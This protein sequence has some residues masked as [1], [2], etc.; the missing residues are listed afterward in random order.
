MKH[1]LTIGIL[2]LQGDVEENRIATFN[3]LLTKHDINGNIIHV[4]YP[5]QIK[6][7]DGLILPGGESTVISILASIN[8]NFLQI[9]KKR[10]DEGIPVLGTCAGMIMLSKKAYDKRIGET[11]QQ[12]ISSLDI[13]IERNAFGRQAD[14]FEIDL[15]ITLSKGEE[16][17]KS[18]RSIFIRAPIVIE[19][20]DKV[21]PIAKFND[22]IVAVKQE[23]I[24]GTAFHPELSND[25]RIHELL[26][27]EI[28]KF[29]NQHR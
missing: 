5:E 25:T 19:I 9:I 13:V 2:G 17:I 23:N 26:I 27:D 1:N 4:R 7:I 16:K 22:K 28:I 24:I 8:G 21:E 12:L 11:K 10:I 15:D 3:A 20:G 18:F 6:N 29:K 14:S